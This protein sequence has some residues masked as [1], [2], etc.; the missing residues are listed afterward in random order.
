[1]QQPSRYHQILSPMLPRRLDPVPVLLLMTQCLILLPLGLK[2]ATLCVPL[3][4]VAY[5]VAP[6]AEG[7]TLCSSDGLTAGELE[8]QLP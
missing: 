7:C 2:L 8:V 3:R 4:G 5:V 1:M 6:R